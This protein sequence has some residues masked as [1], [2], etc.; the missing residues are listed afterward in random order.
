MKLGPIIHPECRV[1]KPELN[2]AKISAELN[3]TKVASA[4][5]EAPAIGQRLRTKNEVYQKGT[6]PV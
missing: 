4:L 3:S 1:A 5:E 2:N 6:P